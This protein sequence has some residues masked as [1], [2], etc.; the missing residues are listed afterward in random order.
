MRESMLSCT[1]SRV[2]QSV[3]SDPNVG[4]GIWFQRKPRSVTVFERSR[5]CSEV[6]VNIFFL[7][8]FPEIFPVLPLSIE[9]HQKSIFTQKWVLLPLSTCF[10]KELQVKGPQFGVSRWRGATVEHILL[11]IKDSKTLFLLGVA[12]VILN[13]KTWKRG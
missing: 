1:T 8:Q 4:I 10:F 7:Y 12:T 2:I 3:L 6:T 5:L 9:I 11:V 13:V